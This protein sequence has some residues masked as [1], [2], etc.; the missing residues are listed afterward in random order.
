[1]Y[2]DE[3]YPK[4]FERNR[5]LLDLIYDTVNSAYFYGYFTRITD[6]DEN[7][8]FYN[9]PH[10]SFVYCVKGSAIYID[11]KTGNEYKVTPG[12]VIQHMPDIPHYTVMPKNTYWKGFHIT[13]SGYIFEALA[14][15]GAV[16]REPVF[17]VGEDEEIHEKLIA[18]DEKHKNYDINETYKMIPDFADII[19]FMHHYKK[20]SDDNQWANEAIKILSD[21]TNVNIS[22]KDVAQKCNMDYEIMRKQFKKVF[23]CSMN[24]Y[25]IKLRINEAKNLLADNQSIKEVA[26]KLGYCDSYAFIRQFKE[27]TGITPGKFM[28]QYKSNI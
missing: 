4:D 23:G 28:S 7:K 15:C 17:Y 19:L 5:K 16:S 2:L 6:C 22:L 12:C 21:C 27:Q 10:Y 14:K 3:K 20:T 8:T 18:Y 1:M 24:E 13:G 11:A 26:K 25:R 9:Q